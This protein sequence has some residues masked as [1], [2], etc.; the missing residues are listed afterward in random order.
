MMDATVIDQLARRVDRL[1][2][3]HEE[4]L[5]TQSLLQAEV[6]RLTQERD[7]LRMQCRQAQA[8]LEALLQRLD[9]QEAAP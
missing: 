3:R 8:R 2:L 5:R 9:P 1:L 4:L 6:Q 7:R